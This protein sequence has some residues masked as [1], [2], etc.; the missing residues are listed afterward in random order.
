VGSAARIQAPVFHNGTDFPVTVMLE[1]PVAVHLVS[2]A[3]LLV[4]G[5]ATL[6]FTLDDQYWRVDNVSTSAVFVFKLSPTEG[7]GPVEVTVRDVL[8]ACESE[9]AA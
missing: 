1:T 5:N 3:G 7:Y 8:C 6:E 4:V 9:R 2:A